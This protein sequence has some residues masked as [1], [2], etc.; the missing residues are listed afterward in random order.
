MMSDFFFDIVAPQKP[1]IVEEND[2]YYVR[3]YP[4]AASWQVEGGVILESKENNVWV[5]WI[6]NAPKRSITVSAAMPYGIGVNAT[7]T[8]N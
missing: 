5:A 1:E 3:P 2:H 7:K 4:F 6:G 8:I